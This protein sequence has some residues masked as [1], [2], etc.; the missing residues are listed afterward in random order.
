MGVL[1]PAQLRANQHM[2]DRR[3]RLCIMIALA[4]IIVACG[5]TRSREDQATIDACGATRELKTLVEQVL[6]RGA[7]LDDREGVV[8]RWRVTEIAD[9]RDADRGD[10][11]LAVE[12]IA[13]PEI[14]SGGRPGV[15]EASIV[16]A[17]ADTDV[18]SAVSSVLDDLRRSG[19]ATDPI[20]STTS[21][22]I[23]LQSNGTSWRRTVAFDKSSAGQALR[24]SVTMSLVA[25]NDQYVNAGLVSVPGSA[26][27]D[28]DNCF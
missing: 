25:S 4:S 7:T 24:I 18:E 23:R 17:V 26:F 5:D 16:Y 11:G 6:P 8:D 15:V 28:V 3:C 12:V 10:N 1:I 27:V 2:S 21:G 22:I 20:P 14:E 13:Y 9:D 19:D